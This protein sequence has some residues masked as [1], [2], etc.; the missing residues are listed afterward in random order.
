MAPLQDP[1]AES[2]RL[3]DAAGAKNV[4]VR[5][6]GGV[7]VYLQ[8][9]AQGPLPKRTVADIDIATRR[10]NRSSVAQVLAEAGYRADEMFNALHGSRRM[11]FYDEVNSRK[12]DVFVGEF[13]MCHLIPITDRLERDP[14]TV[15]LAELLLT[16][17]QIVELTERDQKD[18]YTLAY[19]HPVSNGDGSG[20]EGDYVA[21]ICA[22][23]WG[24]WRTARATIERCKENLPG[25]GL[26]PAAASLIV[27][28]LDLLWARIEQAPKTAKW[29]LRSRVGDRV[30]WY[31]EPE[32][33][34]STN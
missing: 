10:G 5:L 26:E 6:L 20:I 32:E 31:D 22:K 21:E 9:P 25:Y 34:A 7:A 33:H 2:R 12:L 14:L 18:I 15:P 30:R 28:R 16:K 29:R 4:T 23:D 19:H 24:L 27:E 17:L 3:V 11:L 13:S 1:I 8:A